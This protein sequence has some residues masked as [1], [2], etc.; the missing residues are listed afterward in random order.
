MFWRDINDKKLRPN[1]SP[2]HCRASQRRW[3]RVMSPSARA[4]EGT[5]AGCVVD[6]TDTALQEGLK[7]NL[8][9]GGLAQGIHSASK[10]LDQRSTLLCMPALNYD[11]PLG[12]QSLCDEDPLHGAPNQPS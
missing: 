4:G 12:M 5:G 6:D 10:V 11:E 8:I 7:I 9:Q 3:L 2:R 1:F